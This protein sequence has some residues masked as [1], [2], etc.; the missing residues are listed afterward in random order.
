MSTFQKKILVLSHISELLGGA[1]RSML[2]VAQKLEKQYGYTFE[3]I[4]REPLGNIVD[5]LNKKGWK[6]YSLPY[7]FWSESKF[8]EQLYRQY[9]ASNINKQAVIDIEKIIKKSKPDLVLTN[10]VVCPWAAIAALHTGTPHAWFIREYGD[11]D[12]GREFEIGREKTFED[13]ESLSEVVITNSK[14]LTAHTKKYIKN[15]DVITLYHPFDTENMV[16]LS[17]S[18]IKSRYKDKKSLKIVI[19]GSVT[20]SKGQAQAI[21]AIG[22]L[23]K[24]GYSAEIV[25][26]G[27]RGEKNTDKEIDEIVQQYGIKN[28]V[29]FIRKIPYREALAHIKGADVGIMASRSE[30]FG[31]VTFEYMTLG[32]PVVGTKAG[33]TVEMITDSENGFLYDYGNAQQLANKLA[34][35]IA[36][37]DLIK[38]HGKVSQKKSDEMMSGE[39]NL[40]RFHETL[41]SVTKRGFSKPRPIHYLHYWI[42]Q[43]EMVDEHVQKIRKQSLGQ[44]VRRTLYLRAKWVYHGAKNFR[45]KTK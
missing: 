41:Q 6:Y 23:I 17:K 32:K 37:P 1:E 38:K 36:N 14:T 24:K 4:I 27:K 18:P 39:F 16:R 13:I 45:G 42:E 30:A 11:I 20:E 22:I 43:N 44:V 10:T 31:R 2:E 35:Y 5:E 3:F 15:V 21:E 34:K 7:T 12:H 25:V 33:A 29:H 9:I 26:I 40:D 28:K 8:P 19:A